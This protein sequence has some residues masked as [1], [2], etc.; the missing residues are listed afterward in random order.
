MSGILNSGQK[1]LTGVD[2]HKQ[3]NRMEE[4]NKLMQQYEQQQ[5]GQYSH[6]LPQYNQIL[7]YFAHRAGLGA[8]APGAGNTQHAPF[9][10]STGTYQSADYTP[11]SPMMDRG[12]NNQGQPVS[13]PRPIN[14]YQGPV[15][16]PPVA[17]SPFSNVRNV[18][19]TAQAGMINPMTGKRLTPTGAGD[20]N[21]EM[22]P[23]N[24]RNIHNGEYDP[25]NDP[26]YWQW[27][28]RQH[29]GD[30]RGIVQLGNSPTGAGD[31]NGVLSPE[32]Q[33]RALAMR[34]QQLAARRSYAHPAPMAPSPAPAAMPVPSMQN[35]TPAPRPAQTQPPAPG[36]FGAISQQHAPAPAASGS[37][38][39]M[40]PQAPPV[41]PVTPPATTPPPVQAPRP[42]TAQLPPAQQ[43]AAQAPPQPVT[44]PQP[45]VPKPTPTAPAA[46]ISSVSNLPPAPQA[47][48]NPYLNGP[49]MAGGVTNQQ[50][51]IY[52]GTPEDQLR[53][54]AAQDDINR[55]MQQQQSQIQHQLGQRGMLDSSV[56]GGA[57]SQLSNN[58]LQQYSDYRRQLATGAG[59]EQDQRMQNLLN[60]L[61]PSLGGGQQAMGGLNQ[62]YGNANQMSQQSNQALQGL[63]QAG[64]QMLPFIL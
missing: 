41:R 43:P 22:M 7:D 46:P 5:M 28:M 48:Q 1:L 19:T 27:W 6:A 35:P 8:G 24:P 44:V 47:N 42:A 49:A 30:R 63:F 59:Q 39:G 21:G 51:G 53:N 38:S 52:N 23:F 29:G 61:N 55:F 15:A 17:N 54:A 4:Y 2:Q 31:P 64:M 57:L 18:G 10:P 36:I 32:Q 26:E 13:S 58:A 33:Q 3:Q 11:P 34:Q 16:P 60:A 14:H 56:Y 37:M 50:L 12:L 62:L 40:V 20:P 45:P 9:N 25:T